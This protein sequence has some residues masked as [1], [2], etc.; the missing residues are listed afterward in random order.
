MAVQMTSDMSKMDN[1]EFF[2]YQS[3]GK[4]NVGRI[5]GRGEFSEVRLAQ[6]TTNG[7]LVAVKF[8]PMSAIDTGKFTIEDLDREADSMDAVKGPHTMELL[9]FLKSDRY[10]YMVLP[11]CSRGSL[12]SLV[13]GGQVKGNEPKCREYFRKITTAVHFCHSHS[14]AHRD[15]KPE[16]FMV[17]DAGDFIL[18]DFG[19]ACIVKDPT[20]YQTLA[21]GTPHYM[22]PEILSERYLPYPVDVWS[23][24]VVLYVLVAGK[25]PFY[26]NDPDAVFEKV[27]NGDYRSLEGEVSDDCWD[28]IQKILVVDPERRATLDVV[29]SHPWYVGDDSGV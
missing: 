17:N 25:M 6:D 22:A 27:E 2:N 16:N 21:C 19:F 11:L 9:D 12:F 28:L 20:E 15:I 14:V 13:A 8:L 18:S 23:L 5:L 7:K 3:V 4:Y 1:M 26:G 24:G 29:M 10:F